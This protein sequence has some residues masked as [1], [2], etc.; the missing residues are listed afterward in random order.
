MIAFRS[1]WNS[2]REAVRSV[3]KSATAVLSA[4]LAPAFAAYGRGD[5]IQIIG[6]RGLLGFARRE[7]RVEAGDLVGLQLHA[8][9][10]K[11][12]AVGGA[13]GFVAVVGG[14]LHQFRVDGPIRPSAPRWIR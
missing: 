6:E 10:T 12:D 2:A 13:S 9:L 8:I 3:T 1:V 7:A 4:V 5:R 14:V 11:L